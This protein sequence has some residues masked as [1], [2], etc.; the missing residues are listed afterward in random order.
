MIEA[1][2]IKKAIKNNILKEND[3]L[4]LGK[5][6]ENPSTTRSI[7]IFKSVGTA[8]QDISIANKVIQNALNNNIGNFITL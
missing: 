5:V 6:I 2:E 1:G 3:L 7:T 8:A 4:E